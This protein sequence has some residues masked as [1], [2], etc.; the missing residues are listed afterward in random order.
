VG[1]VV[2]EHVGLN[3]WIRSVVCLLATCCVLHDVNAGQ[4]KQP[5]VQFP[6]R[7]YGIHRHPTSA[8]HLRENV[9][10]SGPQ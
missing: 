8:T 9:Q 7:S 1:G 4:P 2:L 6:G 5:R 3:D 10:R